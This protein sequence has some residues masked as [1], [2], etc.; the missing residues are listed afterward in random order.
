MAKI[1]LAGPMS[2]FQDFNRTAF[3]MKHLELMEAGHIVLSPAVLPAGLSD[4]QYMDI[5]FAMLRAADTIYMLSGWEHSAGAR[6]ENALAE[7]LDLAILFQ[8]TTQ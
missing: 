4:T 6:A 8:E 1:Y 2:G 7:K 3:Q 5:C